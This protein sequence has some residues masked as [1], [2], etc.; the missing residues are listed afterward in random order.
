MAALQE[1]FS[2]ADASAPGH[3]GPSQTAFLLLDFHSLF[4][5]HVGGPAAVA[6]CEAAAKFRT[7]AK[8]QGILVIHGLIDIDS[9]PF[10]TC[11]G[12]SG[13]AGL[14]TK[15][16]SGGGKEPAELLEDDG[17]DV[18][19]TRRLGH[20]SALKSP[21]L[22]E[23]LQKRGIK[24]LI[25]TGL[26]TSGCVLR[27]A[28]T[29]CDAEYVVTVL[30]DGCADPADGVHDLMV[31]KVLNGRGYVTTSSEFQAGFVEATGNR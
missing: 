25:L 11:K 14:L 18:T 4:V 24:S 1:T 21:G 29:A 31:G 16:Q 5:Q 3:Y 20:V 12:F 19:F 2:T 7:W 23:F 17:D 30:S 26:S 8:S 22:E 15:M 27:T 13:F 10:F 6:A 28:V 9:T